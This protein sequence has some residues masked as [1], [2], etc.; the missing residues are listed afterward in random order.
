MSSKCDTFIA[1]LSNVTPDDTLVSQLYLLVE[2]IKD[3]KDISSVFPA[4]FHLFE[5]FPDADFG[6]PGP[7]VHLLERHYPAYSEELKSSLKR[8]PTSHTLW[9]LNRILNSSLSSE[10]RSEFL[11]LMAASVHHPRASIPT[12]EQAEEYHARQ[13]KA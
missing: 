4:V 7:L 6:T 9:M 12:R 11:S 3:E 2:S 10:L 8:F 5:R 13:I 1:G